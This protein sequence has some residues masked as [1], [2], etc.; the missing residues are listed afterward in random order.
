[1]ILPCILLGLFVNVQGFNVDVANFVTDY[2]LYKD[3]K[4][5]CYF[6][7]ESRYYNTILAHKLTK[8]GVR[9]SMRRIDKDVD[10]KAVDVARIAYQRTVAVGM[11]IDGH[12]DNT[13]T[14]LE[15]ASKNKLFDAMH[16]WLVLTDIVDDA[17]NCTDYIEDTFKWLN[18]SIDADIAVVA[19]EGDNYTMTDVYNFGRIQGNDLE[20]TLLGTW[21]PDTGLNIVLKGYKYYNRWNFHNLTLRAI[22]VIVDQPEVFYP[23]MLS[24]MAFTPGVAAM[25][26]ITSQMLNTLK[27][28]HNFRFNYSIAGRWIGSPERNSTL[29]V[30]NALFWEE[31]DLSSTCARIFPNWLDWVD[32]YH[33]PTTNLQTKFYYLIPEK[34]VGKYENQFLTPMSDGVWG[35]AFLAGIACTVVL[36]VAARIEKRPKSGW[37]AF[38]SV[39]A[40]ICQQDFEDGVQ[41]LEETFSS[42]G[43]KATL[44][45]IGLTS[46]L[47]Y[48]YYTSSVV[49]WLLNAAA[50]S[51]A[52]LDGLI[53]SDFELI[54]EDIGYTRGWLDNPGF[55]YYS[56]FTNAKED[57]LRDKKV[58]KAKRT[59]AVLQTV[60]TGV[61]LLRTGKYAFHTEP[62]SASQ[63][64]SK[65]YEDAELC[66]LG[67][68]QMMLPAHVYIMAQKR[69][70]Y[71]EFFDWSLLRLT[72]RGHV[73]AIRARFAGTMP[74]CSGAQPR[75]L[76]LGQAAPAFLTLF[77]FAVLAYIILAFEFLCKRVQ[78]KKRAVSEAQKMTSPVIAVHQETY[79][80]D[81]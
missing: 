23:E 36:A 42:Q 6:T 79:T 4:Y 72:E 46:M 71:K 73:K 7:C 9:V 34:G 81:E 25:T 20:T 18:L 47:L 52:N 80:I 65:T 37:Y 19:K 22:T 11:M 63:V 53:N 55:F 8:E 61:E 41:L 10:T 40:A 67:A 15:Q 45:V 76:A 28:R 1:M 27:E 44:L 17:G 26:K 57:E 70:P 68:L 30:T 43:R 13:P 31:Q 5:V 51:I 74:A 50:P 24:E 3:L 12:C 29:A 38:F 56:G 21:R 66:N 16:P 35:C 33:P 60:K 59:A 2:V 58:T 54:F 64:I 32:I 78:L 75:A 39:F 69:S 49:S 62:Y 48:N 14:L 77:L